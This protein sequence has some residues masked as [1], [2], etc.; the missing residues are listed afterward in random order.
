[1]TI[2]NEKAV[3]IRQESPVL[4]DVRSPEAQL[5]DALT[6]AKALN[7]VISQKK[8]PVMM[9]GE[10]YLEFEDWQTVGQFYGYSVKTG[11]PEP[12]EID[13]VKG[14]KA[15]AYLINFRTGEIVGGAEAYCMRDEP[16]WNTRAKYDYIDNKRVKVGEEPVPWF[17]LASMAQT[18]AGA[19]AFRNRLAWVVV[20]AG[21]KPTPA[22]EIQ[23][24]AHNEP[25]PGGEHWC[26]EHN[27]AFFMRG[28]MKSYAHPI[29]DTGEW[30]HEHTDKP[31]ETTKQASEPAKYGF[32]EAAWLDENLPK[33]A[34]VWPAAQMNEWFKAHGVE[35]KSAKTA[36]AK[37]NQKDAEAFCK[38]ISDRLAMA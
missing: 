23:D 15:K 26:E 36:A 28:K 37:L 10:Q 1:M 19:K 14:A 27:A 29:G 17:Q 6:A 30:C 3:T 31:A 35:A 20:L 8:K 12:V 33:A 5:A 22:E 24:M 16:K 21:Y 34:K 7:T 25:Q 32:I 11:E 4:P 2:G 9:N 18:R 13:G 38:E